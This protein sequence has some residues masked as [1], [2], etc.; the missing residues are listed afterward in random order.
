MLRGNSSHTRPCKKLLS[1][2]HVPGSVLD[3]TD[4]LVD[5]SCFQE[6]H[7]F[8]RMGPWTGNGEKWPHLL[9]TQLPP[10]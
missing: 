9:W 3:P 1:V 6:A 10:L 5:G 8:G 4:K 7:I 2:S